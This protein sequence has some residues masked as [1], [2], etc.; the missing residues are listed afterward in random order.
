MISEKLPSFV[1][2]WHPSISNIAEIIK[3][4]NEVFKRKSSGLEIRGVSGRV[5]L[6]NFA[7]HGWRVAPQTESILTEDFGKQRF[8]RFI[9]RLFTPTR[10]CKSGIWLRP[11][12][13]FDWGLPLP[14]EL[15]YAVRT[16]RCSRRENDWR[17]KKRIG[18]RAAS[19][20]RGEQ[21]SEQSISS[22]T[23]Y[24]FRSFLGIGRSM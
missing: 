1:L 8:L 11:A 14:C 12:L 18:K 3:E 23:I 17:L 19:A 24:F 4:P 2:N 10:F 20:I 21:H 13:Y 5:A 9:S 16:Y 7:F 6:Y 22:D 15:G